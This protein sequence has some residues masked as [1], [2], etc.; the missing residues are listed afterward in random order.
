MIIVERPFDVDRSEAF[1]RFAEARARGD[2]KVAPLLLPKHERRLYVRSV[3]REDHQFRIHNRPEGAQ[4]KFDKLADSVFSFF[5]GTA[6]LYYRDYGGSDPHL[7]LVF[8]L[9]DAHPENFGVMPNEDGTPFFGVNDFDEA[10]VAPFSYDVKRCAVG[11]YIVAKENGMS[12]KHRRKVVR[13]FVRGYLS[14]LT[15]FVKDDRENVFQFRIDNSPKM[16][17]KLLEDALKDRQDFL[18]DLIDTKKGEFK[19][20]GEIVPLSRNIKAFQTV[21]NKYKKDNKIGGKKKP[22]NFFK[23]KD[24]AIKKGSGTASLG[25]DRYFVLVEGWSEA[26]DDCV[27]LEM[28][29]T[30]RSALYGLVP[31]NDFEDEEKAQQIVTAQQ[32]HLVGGDPFYG[33]A[34]INEESFLV[35]ERSP[36]KDDIDIDDLD[37]KEMRIYAEICG[38]ALAQSHA[39]SDEDTGIM[40]GDAEQ[41][42]LASINR[43]LFIKD[44][45]NFTHSAAKRIYKDHKLFKQDHELGA[46]SFTRK[47]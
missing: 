37:K 21:I 31:E 26:V 20:S 45:T 1:K 38:R 42:I 18:E 3:L 34:V 12:E 30:R 22:K 44:T 39:R 41:R 17:R 25:L 5:R 4:A 7:P 36:Y 47:P 2:I 32:V 29:Q 19:P 40:E 28:K 11:F 9:G 10:W 46:F 8:T 24:G 16:I 13:A 14:A 43:E 27:I 33:R 35:R 23:V 15:Q 6:L